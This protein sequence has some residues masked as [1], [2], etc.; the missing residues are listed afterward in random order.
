MSLTGVFLKFASQ[1]NFLSFKYILYYSL[2]LGV[3]A[4]Y[5]VFW[6]IILKKFELYI[7][8]GNKAIGTV[9]AFVWSYFIFN[10]KI[11]LNM[12]IGAALII[13]GSILMV[14]KDVK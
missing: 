12:I 6:Q 3:L 1:N 11:T 2:A 4:V 5:A 8:Y 14:T 13:S 10:D 7:A 9:W